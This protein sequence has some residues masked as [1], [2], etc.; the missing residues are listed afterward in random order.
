MAMDPGRDAEVGWCGIGNL[1]ELQRATLGTC[2]VVSALQ[3]EW[4]GAAAVLSCAPSSPGDELL[5]PSAV[6]QVSTCTR[7]VEVTLQEHMLCVLG[8]SKG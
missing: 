1:T 8:V 7:L 3:K 2:L 6:N 4:S 5:C